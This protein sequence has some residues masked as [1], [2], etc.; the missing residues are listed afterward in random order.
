M[1]EKLNKRMP[2][3]LRARNSRIDKLDYKMHNYG[4]SAC[5]NVM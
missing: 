4:L 5:D 3:V 1:P 2:S